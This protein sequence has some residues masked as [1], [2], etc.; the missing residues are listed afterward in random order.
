MI[1]SLLVDLNKQDPNPFDLKLN[2]AIIFN[3]YLKKVQLI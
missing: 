2:S 1:T 3:E